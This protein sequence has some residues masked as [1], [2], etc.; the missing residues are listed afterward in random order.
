MRRLW[1]IVAVDSRILQILAIGGILVPP[2]TIVLAVISALVTPEH[3]I[4]LYT[5]SQAAVEG[6]PH[7]EFIVSAFLVYGILVTGFAYSLGRTLQPGMA[8]RITWLLF[9]IHGICIFFVGI[10]RDDPRLMEVSTA[11]GILHN[12]FAII[13]FFLF[14][15]GQLMFARVASENPDWQRFVRP[16]VIAAIL[17]LL[18]GL[19]CQ[20]NVLVSIEGLLQRIFAFFALVWIE[21]ISVRLLW[22]TRR[23]L[24]RT[25]NH[26]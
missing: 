11:S 10:F 7:P 16:T 19:L 26:E 25:P 2:I 8:P 9:A 21:I 12:T 17:I 14:A 22:L 3:D 5:L 18:V 13:G 20:F 24:T 4:I 1:P 23:P 6:Q 15:V